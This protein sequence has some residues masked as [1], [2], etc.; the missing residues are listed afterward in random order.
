MTL[1]LDIRGSSLANTSLND[2][3]EVNLE[4]REES[5][6]RGGEGEPTISKTQWRCPNEI[7]I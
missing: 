6:D 5:W 2:E 1:W 7:M 4:W 3:N